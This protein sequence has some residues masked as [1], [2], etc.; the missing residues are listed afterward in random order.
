MFAHCHVNRE[1]DSFD[2]PIVSNA[3]FQ[4]ESEAEVVEEDKAHDSASCFVE[5]DADTTCQ[6]YLSD[7]VK[8]QSGEHGTRIDRYQ[9]LSAL[10]RMSVG[11]SLSSVSSMSDV[12]RL[13]Q[14][15]VVSAQ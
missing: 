5:T 13:S 14:F 7:D 9:M 3:S 2:H 4:T 8:S 12:G 15:H 11:G 10:A 6:E 1:V